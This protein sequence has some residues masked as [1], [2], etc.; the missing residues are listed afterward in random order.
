VA[1]MARWREGGGGERAR[2]SRRAK[3]EARWRRSEARGG[4][5]LS[6]GS[7]LGEAPFASL[8]PHQGP[9]AKLGS[10]APRL[11]SLCKS[12]AATHGL[13]VVSG[14][15]AARVVHRSLFG[16]AARSLVCLAGPC[17]PLCPSDLL[18]LSLDADPR[19]VTQKLHHDAA[20]HELCLLLQPLAPAPALF[21]GLSRSSALR[22]AE[23]QS[24]VIEEVEMRE[25][26]R[27]DV[28][29]LKVAL[30]EGEVQCEAA[31]TDVSC[32]CLSLSVPLL[33][34]L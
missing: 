5:R 18:S 12:H 23:R 4:A 10:S 32:S 30:Q 14:A 9:S 26:W 22:R 25:A 6:G 34:P 2:R 20:S 16:I 29:R 27:K 13:D 28:Q 15:V 33:T 11:P 21:E 8:P 1:N 3:D 19:F 17:I 24:G 31:R 7:H